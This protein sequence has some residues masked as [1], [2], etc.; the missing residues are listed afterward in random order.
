MGKMAIKVKVCNTYIL[1]VLVAYF[2]WS[3]KNNDIRNN[4][5][6]YWSS[7]NSYEIQFAKI[8]TDQWN[9]DHP[10]YKISFQPVPEGQ[11]SE[12]VILAAV[13]G[14]T[15]PDL[16]SNMWQGD[17]EA[18]A[19]ANVLIALD[20][21]DGF[22]DFIYDR[23][24]SSVIL[25]ITSLDGH[26]YQIPWKIN[27]IMLIYN[28]ALLKSIGLKD[29]PST[30]SEFYDACEKFKADIDG[31]G[32]TDRWFGYAEVQVTWWQRFFDFYPLYLA[33][34]NG[35]PL[36]KDEK[37]NFNNDAAVNVFAFLRKLY[38]HEYFSTE[39]LSARQD[40]FLSSVIATRF[41]G[42]WE[43]MHADNFKPAGFEY[44]FVPMPV[45][46]GHEGPS[47]TYGDPKNIVIFKT[48]SNPQKAWQFLQ[49]ILDEKVELDLLRITNQLPRRKDLLENPIFKDYFKLNPKMKTFAEQ[50]KFVKGTDASPYL[51]EVF[52]LISQEYE[53]CVVYG[54][55]SPKQAIK[56]AS[57]AVDLLYLK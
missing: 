34:S 44:D 41:T 35:A 18:Y 7:N 3:C 48:C 1:L 4:S 29:P 22:L 6:T 13:V 20:T 43:I 52:D 5:L 39:R 21:L 45:P 57:D 37:S 46:N 42:P 12:E 10:E 23:C 56:D 47:F 33:A 36:I 51:K 11:S 49:F 27:P 53:A 25:E 54:I 26:I 32:Y 9:K 28:K 17:V 38:E 24:D 30:Y 8:V 16:Y 14:E 55:K 40:V 31:D 15:T 19:Q 2:A 50:A